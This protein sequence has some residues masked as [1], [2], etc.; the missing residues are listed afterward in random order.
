MSEINLL[1]RYPRVSRD[2]ASRAAAAPAQR[3]IARRFGREYFDGDRGQGYGGYRYDGRWVPIAERLRDHYRLGAGHH[4]LDVGCAKGFLLHD[5]R[6]V[7]PGLRV[8]GLD[9]SAYAL[10]EAMDD[11]RGGLVRGNAERLPFASD[12]FDLV[13]SINTIHNLG[14]AACI[15]A[16]REI[17]RVSRRHRYVQVDSWL[18][19]EQREKFE[20]WQLTAATYSDPDGWRRLFREAGYGGDYYWTVTE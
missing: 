3:A 11:V 20:R 2:I 15:E 6:R 4:V 19:E 9:I 5:L 14:R 18:T 1:D 13:L 17:E 8:T 10:G 7:V 12:A 16:L